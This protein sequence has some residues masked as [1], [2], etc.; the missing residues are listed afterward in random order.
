MVQCMM[1]GHALEQGSRYLE[2]NLNWAVLGE[3]T[4]LSRKQILQFRVKSVDI[5]WVKMRD[6]NDT[7]SM[8]WVCNPNF[9]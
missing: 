9:V 6:E 5:C 4:S 2:R 3:T 1:I 8:D 7:P